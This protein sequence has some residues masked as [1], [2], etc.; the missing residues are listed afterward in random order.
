[1]TDYHLTRLFTWLVNM[2]G[3]VLLVSTAVGFV[4]GVVASIALPDDPSGAFA[5]ASVASFLTFGFYLAFADAP[6]PLDY[7]DDDEDDV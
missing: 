1:M 6:A 7:G 3:K 4:V 5:L 2:A